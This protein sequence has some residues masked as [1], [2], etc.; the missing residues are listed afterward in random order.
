[1]KYSQYVD[2]YNVS[3]THVQIWRITC[4]RDVSPYIFN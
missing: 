4:S 2:T 3:D 1:M